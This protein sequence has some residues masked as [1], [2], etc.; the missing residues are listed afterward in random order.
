MRR[1]KN[2]CLPDW[3]SSVS[4]DAFFGVT[5]ICQIFSIHSA[6][7]QRTIRVG[8]IPKISKYAGKKPLW[9]VRLVREFVS[10]AKTRSIK[11]QKEQKHERAI[12]RAITMLENDGYKVIAP[13]S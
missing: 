6:N 7:V 10:A 2:P 3:T 9:N 5:E 13:N 12:Q 1:L 11:T 8:G 4:N